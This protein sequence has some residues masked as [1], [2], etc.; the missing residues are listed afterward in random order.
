MEE[1]GETAR[2][3]GEGG[4]LE[5]EKSLPSKAS[6]A[7][8]NTETKEAEKDQPAEPEVGEKVEVLTSSVQAATSQRFSPTKAIT[9]MEEFPNWHPYKM[10]LHVELY[11]QFQSTSALHP[12]PIFNPNNQELDDAQRSVATKLGGYLT[13]CK[14]TLPF[15]DF[16]ASI[17]KMDGNGYVSSEFIQEWNDFFTIP[18]VYLRQLITSFS[19]R[20][21]CQRTC[22]AKKKAIMFG[23]ELKTDHLMHVAY[24]KPKA[25]LK[26]QGNLRFDVLYKEIHRLIAGVFKTF[27]QDEKDSV[28]NS[29]NHGHTYL[30][31]SLNSNGNARILV[32]VVL[33]SADKYGTWINWLAVADETF[34]RTRF[35]KKASEERFRKSGIGTLLLLLVQ[36]RSITYD[37][38]TD[39]YLQ[40]NQEE[41]AVHFYKA[42]GFRACPTNSKMSMPSQWR[43]RINDDSTDTFYLKFVDHKTNKREAEQRAAE[44]DEV[45]NY[46][47]MLHLMILSGPIKTLHYIDWDQHLNR[48]SWKNVAHQIS[49]KLEPLLPPREQDM[50]FRFP[51]KDVGKR[52]DVSTADLTIFGNKLFHVSDEYIFLHPEEMDGIQGPLH[53]KHY[54]SSM[55][56]RWNYEPLQKDCGTYQ[57]WLHDEHLNL[58]C[59]WFL[60]NSQSHAS[61][62]FEVIQSNFLE[63][64]TEFYQMMIN[65][66]GTQSRVKAA[67]EIHRFLVKKHTFL[68]KRFLFFSINC[69][70]QHWIMNC[71]CNPWMFLLKDWRVNG[72][73]KLSAGLKK[74]KDDGF[75]HGWMLFD[76]L[77]G[78]IPEKYDKEYDGLRDALV[79]LMNLS[80]MY[81]RAKTESTLDELD[82]RMYHY[83]QPSQRHTWERR[84]EANPEYWDTINDRDKRP[85]YKNLPHWFTFVAKWFLHGINGPFGTVKKLPKGL[86][87]AFYENNAD[88]AQ[89]V[90]KPPPTCLHFAPHSFTFVQNDSV[91]CGICCLLFMID[92][93]SSQV[94]Q[95]WE[96][97][98]MLGPLLPNT[99]K[100]GSTFYNEKIAVSFSAHLITL[101][102]AFREELVLV[103]QRICLLYL[104][105]VGGLASIAMVP[106]WGEVGTSLKNF[107]K[108]LQGHINVAKHETANITMRIKKMRDNTARKQLEQVTPDLSDLL[109]LNFCYAGIESINETLGVSIGSEID[110]EVKIQEMYS[111]LLSKEIPPPV[112]NCFAV[113]LVMLSIYLQILFIDCSCRC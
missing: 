20:F 104:E 65:A 70:R 45:V 34:D 21:M 87:H 50:M 69:Q 1:Q 8:E 110:L 41:S 58:T 9:T 107:H 81:F 90:W 11:E 111:E 57:A 4:V 3:V 83:L 94:D 42:V 93:V 72:H 73:F 6:P 43:N 55:I 54:S 39:I 99:I 109:T 5:D 37:W 38:S 25:L 96:G 79:W 67:F 27:T 108:R 23:T 74:I 101:C 22:T 13:N 2:N 30:I 98:A 97:K 7:I 59:Q 33:F 105:N 64:V 82:F 40:A 63:V 47:A 80:V 16:F 91:N 88:L 78:F 62:S 10:E 75:I 29:L 60:R 24:F 46:K 35:G 44:N 15:I 100:Y 17:T 84:F 31:F 19:L 61:D 106:G 32:G 51:Y 18:L 56:T 76:P 28:T 49:R 95:S 85:E 92:L 52:L 86:M 53:D 77:H 102:N 71:L 68:F 14:I 36:L 66:D 89:V 12:E 112:S 103:M 48:I 113:Y 26:N